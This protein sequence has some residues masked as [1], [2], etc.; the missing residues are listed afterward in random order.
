MHYFVELKI[1]RRF[2]S[3]FLYGELRAVARGLRAKSIFSALRDGVPLV[4]FSWRRLRY[5]EKIWRSKR[6]DTYC[7]DTCVPSRSSNLRNYLRWIDVNRFF[8]QYSSRTLETCRSMRTNTTKILFAQL[9]ADK[10]IER[11]F[12]LK[13]FFR[14]D[15]IF[16]F[17]HLTLYEQVILYIVFSNI[18]T[19][20]MQ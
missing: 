10:S 20:F 1:I 17:M 4:Q 2:S 12:D 7:F 14:I 3:C 5:P 9:F 16:N 19:V 15:R 6:N 8:L 13:H 11:P 18:F